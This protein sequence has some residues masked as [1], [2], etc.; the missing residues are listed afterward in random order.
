MSPPTTPRAAAD[1]GGA[2][3]NENANASSN[4]FGRAL[5]RVATRLARVVSGSGDG[6]AP[7]SPRSP[8]S[9]RAGRGVTP[10]GLARS[11]TTREE[12]LDTTALKL[13]AE[14]VRRDVEAKSRAQVL[15][16]IARAKA[17]EEAEAS[18]EDEEDDAFANKAE[19]KK[20]NVP[21]YTWSATLQRRLAE[22]E[23]ETEEEESRDLA[24]SSTM[25]RRVGE[26]E[27][28]VA[29]EH[30][31]YLNG[32]PTAAA[33]SLSRINTIN[34]PTNDAGLLTSNV[35]SKSKKVL[36]EEDSYYE[37]VMSDRIPA[38]KKPKKYI[39]RL[40]NLETAILD[41]D[42][43]QLSVV[44]ST[45][46]DIEVLGPGIG[47]WFSQ[48]KI[49]CIFFTCISLLAAIPV[50]HY[51]RMAAKATVEV[52]EEVKTTLGTTTAALVASAYGM[53]I[54]TVMA[55]FSVLDVFSI[56]CFMALIAVLVRRMRKYVMR[57]D[58]AML[59]LADFSVQV[60][61]LPIDAT[62][63]EV[64]DHFEQVGPVAD[65]VIARSYG[66]VLRRRIKR[67]K[68]FQRAELLKFE[69]SAIR[70]KCR[71]A[72]TDV[73]T[74]FYYKRT[75][76]KF[77]QVRKKILVLKSE[78]D[79]RMLEPFNVVYAFVTFDQ[80]SD[81]LTCRNDYIPYFSYFRAQRTKFRVGKDERGR[82]TFH[83]LTVKQ[84]S[85]ASDIMW[86]NMKNVG[87]RQ[88]TARRMFTAI[89]ILLMLLGNILLVV[90]ATTALN[91]DGSLLADCSSI[92]S[93]D[94]GANLNCQEIW[95]MDKDMSPTDV[96][97]ISNKNYRDR[98]G[99]ADCLGFLESSLFKANISK[100]APYTNAL[101][102]YSG[103]SEAEAAV[104]GFDSTGKWQGGLDSET[105][106]DECAAKICYQCACN[107]K[108]WTQS[109]SPFCRD[110][111]NEQWLIFGLEVGR[112]S[113]QSLTS[114]ILL[115]SAA[116]FALFERHKTV[117]STEQTTSRF[118]FFTIMTNTLVLPL[119]INVNIIGLSGFPILFHGSY[120]DIT[121]DWYQA[122]LRGLMISVFINACW[123]GPSR[124]ILAW[125]KQLLRLFTSPWCKTQYSLNKLYARPA[126]TLAERYG[127]CMSVIFISVSLSSAA[128]IL[129]PVSAVYLLLAYWADKV[130]LFRYVRYPALYD[131][132]L[133]KQFLF[134]APIACILHFAFGFW[135]FSQWDIPTYFLKSLSSWD[136]EYIKSQEESTVWELR[137]NMTKYEQLDLETRFHRA[138]GFIQLI[139]L[140]AYALYLT[141]K[142]VLKTVGYSTVTVLG[143]SKYFTDEW[144]APVQFNSFTKAR[145]KQLNNDGF[146]DDALSGLPSYRVQDNPEYAALFPEVKKFER[147]KTGD[148]DDE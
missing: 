36:L 79:Q 143:C 14:A 119:L 114:I 137:A 54:R 19:E 127:Q 146:A 95:N 110:Q 47:L 35:L 83:Y 109:V 48:V 107:V 145:Q 136:G 93:G 144:E 41:K 123:F 8:R 68:L 82:E 28:E 72:D 67:S 66:A 96:I 33:R 103:L 105:L 69:L 55:F 17:L 86:E 5:S 140:M 37:A 46:H 16:D 7:R 30:A 94:D 9:P 141:V 134:Y 21:E 139:P 57:V 133:A 34:A 22:I 43:H 26:I 24:W 1:G 128:P 87:W 3:A 23:S 65:V 39:A 76:D 89:G 62:E 51:V 2:N 99:V 27:E 104:Q 15:K 20:K 63:D 52:D 64:R 77:C 25:E 91:S 97:A 131:Y 59:T 108:Y 106:A 31:R 85:E 4:G 13:D 18:D 38:Y 112:L 135:S 116:K 10:A 45:A 78:I 115:W 60:R 111:Y 42:G 6:A 81:K 74:D 61:G 125:L 101:S 121:I 40:E 12:A 122:V 80:E 117:T 90:F 32:V 71:K 118:A 148:D 56:L 58:E 147:S 120:D 73:E 124:L 130:V 75:W 50:F 11:P 92:S 49:M 126:F 70:H 138:T 142:Q 132:K 88:W 53:D 129:I 113:V 100:Y 102:A 98:V 44:Q 29:Q 84:A